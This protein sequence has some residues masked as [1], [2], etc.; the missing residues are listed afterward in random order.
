MV[1]CLYTPMSSA[2]VIAFFGRASPPFR[3]TD[4][5]FAVF[6]PAIGDALPM[7]SADVIAFSSPPFR[8]TDCYSK[9]GSAAA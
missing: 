7:S 8:G 5:S 6:A 4:T 3:G 9:K 2:D 1:K